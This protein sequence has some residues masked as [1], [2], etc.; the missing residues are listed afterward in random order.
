MPIEKNF[1]KKP[2]IGALNTAFEPHILDHIAP[3]ASL[4]NI[5]LLFSSF[6]MFDLAE[7]YYPDIQ[8]ELCE[9]IEFRL[10]E[11][12]DRFDALIECKYFLPHLKTI[13]KN[14]FHKDMDLIFC[15]HGHSD[16]GFGAPLLAPLRATRCGSSVRPNA[17]RNA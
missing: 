9:D 12:A 2:S 1:M 6:E 14:L 11:L 16:K 13:F 7:T 3:L 5:P 8:K 10:K 4:L 15:P 17:S